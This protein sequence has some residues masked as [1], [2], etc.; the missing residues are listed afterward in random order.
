MVGSA[1]ATMWDEL[2]TPQISSGPPFVRDRPDSPLRAWSSSRT[3][4]AKKP[5]NQGGCLS[6]EKVECSGVL[7]LIGLDT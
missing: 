6:L 2:L 1:V 4:L 3:R 7:V 5:V